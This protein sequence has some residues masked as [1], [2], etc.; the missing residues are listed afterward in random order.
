MRLTVLLLASASL[1][2]CNQKAADG[3]AMPE[4]AEVT[5]A[6]LS[7][8]GSDYGTDEAAK[9]AHGERLS[10]V[11]GCRGCHTETLEG[12]RFPPDPDYPDT[13]IW[14]SN[15]TRVLPDM[16]DAQIEAL[17]RKG[18]H[19]TRDKLWMMPSENLQFI[20]EADLKALIAH[21]RTVEPSGSPT[22][23][24]APTET[25]MKMVAEGQANPP[26][27]DMVRLHQANQPADLGE[28]LALGRHIAMSTCA[29]CHNAKLEGY[30][31]FSP[32]L[33]AVAPMYD[34]AALTKL[35]TTGEGL[36]GRKLG[37]MAIVGQGHF[38]YL[39]DHERKAVI[40]YVHALAEKEAGQPQ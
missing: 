9:L 38:S 26:A 13:G 39:T 10:H 37:L 23:L 1:A 22:P 8:D 17:I 11:L 20:S 21:L 7:Y 3:S 24:P 15:I 40:D 25:F 2:A 27:A 35:L 6:A 30:E 36:E 14:A 16:T 19:P 5:P 32:D 34:D 18:E 28:E 31:G 12:Q 33:R 29:E 4:G